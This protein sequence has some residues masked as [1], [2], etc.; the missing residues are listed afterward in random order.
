MNHVVDLVINAD[1]TLSIKRLVLAQKFMM[2]SLTL[3]E[4]KLDVV[5]RQMEM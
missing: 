3:E 2:W 1:N 5:N 4:I